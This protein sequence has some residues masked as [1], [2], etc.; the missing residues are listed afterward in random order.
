MLQKM[1]IFDNQVGISSMAKLTN[2]RLELITQT[3]LSVVLKLLHIHLVLFTCW[4][5]FHACSCS[6]LTFQN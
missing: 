1:K 3:T 2:S 4:V 5:I 6:L